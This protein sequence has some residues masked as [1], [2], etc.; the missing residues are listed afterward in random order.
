MLKITSIK[1]PRV[2]LARSLHSV[3]GRRRH[4]K[5]LLFDVEQIKW[6]LEAKLFFENIF[7][8]DGMEDVFECNKNCIYYVSEGV[9]KKISD[10]SYVIPYLAVVHI[11]DNTLKPE[12]FVVVMDGLQDLGNI[13]SIVRTAQGLGIKQFIYSSMLQDSFQ[14]KIIDSSRGLVF[15]SSIIEKESALKTIEYLKQNDYQIVVTTPHAKLLQS[16]IRLSEKKI[17]LIVGNESVGVCDELLNIADIAV[18]VP[19]NLNV[20]SLNAAVFA[21][22]SMYELKFKQVVSMLKEKILTN[23]GREVNVTGMFIRMAF[24]FEVRQLTSFS[25]NQVICMMIMHCESGVAKEQ[26]CRDISLLESELQSFVEPLIKEK[27]VSFQDDLYV[28][29]SSGEIFI[30]QI[31]P[32]VERTY[33][34]IFEGFRQEE[35]EQLSFFLK[36]LQKNCTQVFGDRK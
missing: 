33:Q 20:E 35:I 9:L 26:I 6:A 11:P 4:G 27:Y 17:A 36:R 2:E 22:I 7:I 10:T 8:L 14:R 28:L 1:D 25:G 3:S 30:A 34:K 31:W 15:K 5:A 19:M 13:G 16:Q 29:T 23:F 24:D 32:I 18:Q 21:G 12:E